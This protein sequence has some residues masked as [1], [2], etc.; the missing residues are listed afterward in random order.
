MEIFIPDSWYSFLPYF[1]ELAYLV[2]IVL[3][4]L[5]LKRLSSPATARSG[6]KLASLGMLLG[7]VVTLLDREIISF[8]YIL[9]GV[10]IGSLIGA[11]VAKKV[12][13][14]SMPELVAL[15]NGFGGAASALVALGAWFRMASGSVLPGTD[16]FI[17]GLSVLIGA[18]TFT[19]S[20]IAFGKLNGML[21]GNAVVF[22]LQNA[23]N[24][25]LLLAAVFGIGWLLAQPM[26]L[27]PVLLI[28][29]ISLLLGIL[30]VI[31]IGGADMPVVISLLN[32]LSGIAASFA[33]FVIDNNLLIVSGALV[34]AAGLILT[35]IMCKSMNRSL[36]SVLFARFGGSGAAASG[37]DNGDKSIREV[38]QTDVAVM[39]AYAKR[40]IVVPGY[41]LAV[42]Q[43]Q[44]V[45]REV[46]DLLQKKGVDV[47]YGI[48]PVAGRMPG[49]MNVLLAEANV[50]YSQLYDM[51]EINQEFFRTD[52]V[53]VIG[54]NDVVNPQAKNNPS[55]PIY[56][57]PILNVE[58]AKQVVVFKRS[59]NPGY[60]GIENDL[61]YNENTYMYFGDAKNTLEDLVR[62]IKEL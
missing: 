44:H 38:Q 35:N 52:V 34:G 39:T 46:A 60:A 42:A 56:G 58:D 19:G 2:A 7:V 54:A 9:A 48:H 1:V 62:S 26:E 59:M 22:P 16:L 47:R 23:F 3:F 31:R 20:L 13:M 50:P 51:E 36:M 4:I 8:E 14:T 10:V 21:K 41:G 12:E 32:S 49:H 45:I 24:Q 29:G 18:V 33:G 53:L 25:L 17:M 15:F 37:G 61:F 5:G 57:M 28:T 40:V 27:A 55:S 43:A 11:A 30:F 6:N